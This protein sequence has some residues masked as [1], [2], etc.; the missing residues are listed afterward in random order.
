MVREFT[1]LDC[2]CLVASIGERAANDQDI[3]MECQWLRDIED[4]IEREQLRAWL[5]RRDQ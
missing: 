3:C 5:K 4:P 1:C 2:G